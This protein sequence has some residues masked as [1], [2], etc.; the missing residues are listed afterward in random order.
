[1]FS[2]NDLSQALQIKGR[3]KTVTEQLGAKVKDEKGEKGE[4]KKVEK[5]DAATKK[6]EKVKANQD[7]ANKSSAELLRELKTIS[8]KIGA[9]KD[10]MDGDEDEELE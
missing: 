2:V 3:T 5:I 10:A 9:S 6:G 8:D 7:L 4:P 1:M